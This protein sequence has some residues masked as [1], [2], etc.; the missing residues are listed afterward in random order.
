M[1]AGADHSVSAPIDG[2]NYPMRDIDR[3]LLAEI[4]ELLPERLFDVHVHVWRR[5]HLGAS[6]GGRRSATG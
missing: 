2:T 5:D 4:E 6:G 3:L 1:S